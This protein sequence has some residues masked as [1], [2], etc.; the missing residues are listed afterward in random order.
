MFYSCVFLRF[1]FAVFLSIACKRVHSLS[2]FRLSLSYL[3]PFAPTFRRQENEGDA[4][5]WRTAD[6]REPGSLSDGVRRVSR[7]EKQQ[8]RRLPQPALRARTGEENESAM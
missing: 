5:G 1:Y 7:G 4:G 6:P 3:S 8:Q 2:V